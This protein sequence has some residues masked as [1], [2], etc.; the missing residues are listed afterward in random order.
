MPDPHRPTPA[1]R[2]LR[3]SR[4]ATAT[5]A[6]A[7]VLVTAC[8]SSSSRSA[9]TTTEPAT[10]AAATTAT[11]AAAASGQR[12]VTP[13]RNPYLADSAMPIG[14][15][16][17]AQSNSTPV[18]GPTGPSRTLQSSDLQYSHLGPG[19]FGIAISPTYTDGSRVVWSNGGDRI[20][21]LDARTMRVI[22]ELPLPGRTL[23]S[24]AQAD[25]AIAKLDHEHGMQLASTAVAYAAQYLRGLAGV[26]YVLDKDNTLFVGGADSV[27]AYGDKV[28]GDPR[29]PIVVR[30]TWARPASVPGSF[31]GVNVT[32]DG[33]LV[34]VTDEGWVVVLDRDFKH[35]TA[36]PMLGAEQA[37]AHNQAVVKRGMQ[38]GA[39]SW[40]R[41]S[42]AVDDHGGIYV[43]SVD[44][45]QKLVWTGSKL[46][47]DPADGAWSVP[48]LD[49]DGL[50]TGATPALMGFCGN[51]RFV[52][53]TD[54]QKLMNVVLFWRAAIPSSWKQL[55]GAPTRRI[56]GMLPADMGNPNQRAIQTEQGVVV[57]GYGA[58]VVNNEPAS[59]PS[60]F[61]AAAVR[62][63]AGYAGAD[64]A[65]TPHGLEKFAW[66]TR[67]Q[68]FRK[69]W[70]NTKISSANAVPVVSLGSNILYTV[71]ARDGKW[72]LE[73][74]DW[75][76]G[77]SRFT[78]ITGSSRYNT[79]FSG[80]N[81]DGD[82][83]VVHTT[84]F[85]IVR[86]APGG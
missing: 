21:K 32:Y 5:V 79:N 77:A 49:G 6:L 39:G 68:T 2:S 62:V 63:L 76:T 23:Q 36:A 81:I 67:S 85:G 57:G 43:A 64:P 15:V 42:V 55:T 83:H 20:S 60:G 46:S 53:I 29:S 13:P 37:A 47:S 17:A 35:F 48:Y 26:Y 56:A 1:A 4:A 14:H 40:V 69:A 41:N 34:L 10:T 50:G 75:T 72:A 59:I 66:D 58:L 7:A 31:T 38:L 24:G 78:W 28:A 54:G 65:F 71:G 51:D 82:G 45:M 22:T 73:G 9:P 19:H 61:P 70:V 30:G 18:A 11:S 86:Y 84:E 8:S 12:C 52:V 33:K 80:I 74:L 16:D 3:A 27:V 44:H 25:A